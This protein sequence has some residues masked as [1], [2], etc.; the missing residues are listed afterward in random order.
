MEQLL[1]YLCAAAGNVEIIDAA[2]V[3]ERFGT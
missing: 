1:G 3:A 2:Q